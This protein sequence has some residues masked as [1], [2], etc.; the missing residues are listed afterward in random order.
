[1]GCRDFDIEPKPDICLIRQEEE[2]DDYMA[3]TRK[4]KNDQVCVARRNSISLKERTSHLKLPIECTSK[5]QGQQQVPQP[6]TTTQSD[7]KPVQPNCE[8]SWSQL[9]HAEIIAVAS[10]MRKIR[11]GLE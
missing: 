11:G 9:V 1:M 6:R 8:L 7:E 2:K 5:R 10:T 4:E 3:E